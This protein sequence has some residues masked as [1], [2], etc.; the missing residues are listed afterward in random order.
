LVNGASFD[1]GGIEVAEPFEDRCQLLRELYGVHCVAD[2]ADL[3]GPE[4]VIMAVKPQ[5]FREVSQALAASE[6]FAP[7]RVISIAAGITTAVMQ[8]CFSGCALVRVMP[9]LNLSVSAGMSA[10]AAA[11]GTPTH[12]AELVAELFSLMGEAVIIDEGLID[13]ATA[14]HGSGPAYYALFTEVLSRCGAEAG[15]PEEIAD[16]LARQTIIG[17]GRY[18]E[19]LDD[20]PSDL[21][22]AV[23]SPGGTTQAALESFEAQGFE[24]VVR[25]AF[26]ACLRRA[27]ELA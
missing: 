4:T 8:E 1:A 15:L 26:N 12:E 22:A 10:V 5:I 7:K 24:Q 3:D 23:T 6:G 2:G 27:K 18:L 11:A 21:R 20:S 25:D 16:K 19:L 13:V 14:V 17:T 9:N